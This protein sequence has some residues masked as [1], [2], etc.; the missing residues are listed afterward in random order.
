MIKI[1]KRLFNS[2]TKLNFIG[3]VLRTSYIAFL[4]VKLTERINSMDN[5]LQTKF[6]MILCEFKISILLKKNA[7]LIYVD[8]TEEHRT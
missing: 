1:L 2:N 5:I 8:I 6:Y 7:N 4:F 3:F